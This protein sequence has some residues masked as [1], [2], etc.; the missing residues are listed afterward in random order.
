MFHFIYLLDSQYQVEDVLD[1]PTSQNIPDVSKL[2]EPIL[3]FKEILQ[4]T[5]RKR[6]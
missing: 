2:K 6:H 3:S 4:I 1:T 5:D